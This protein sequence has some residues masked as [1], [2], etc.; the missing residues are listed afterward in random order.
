MQE[1]EQGNRSEQRSEADTVE[2]GSTEPGPIADPSPEGAESGGELLDTVL[3]D[4]L[5]ESV[6]APLEFLAS[7]PLLLLPV[8]VGVGFLLGKVLQAVLTAVGQRITRR[9]KGDYDDRLL[10]IARKPLLTVPVLLSLMLVTAIVPLPGLAR[11]ITVNVLATLILFSLTRAALACC[12]VILEL[13]ADSRDQFDIIEA[14]TLP[15]FDITAN[16]IIVAV[17]GYL[18][19]LIWGIDPTAWLASAG[20]IG[21]AVGFAARDTLANLFSGIFIVV[22]SPYKIGDYVVLDTGERGEVTHVGLRSTRLL[23]RDDV[24]VTIPNAIIANAKIINES[25]G[26]WEKYRIRIPVGVAYGSDVDQVSEVLEEEARSH[27]DILDYPAPRVRMRAFGAFSL[28]FELL[29]WVDKPVHRGRVTDS[30]LKSIYKRFQAEGITIPFPQTDV[31]LH[32]MGQG[33]DN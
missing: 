5:P 8:L 32:R 27:P 24:E 4:L 33:E 2:A 28:D 16:V 20:V 26:P 3:W 7:Y 25:G 17:A 18:G 30:L 13:L 23:T 9:T 19:L 15:M 10:A 14:R 31:Y 22:D 29:G 1:S 11:E 12:H 21:I 6:Q